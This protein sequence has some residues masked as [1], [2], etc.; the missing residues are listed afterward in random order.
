MRRF[1]LK[2]LPVYLGVQFAY[3]V[4]VIVIGS[5]AMAK[6]GLLSAPLEVE[7]DNW[8]QSPEGQ[9]AN[10]LLDYIGKGDK[11]AAQREYERGQE[12]FGWKPAEPSPRS[13]PG[14]SRLGPPKTLPPEAR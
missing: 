5:L 6:P 14:P 11:A 8:D 9:A 3:L 4:F 2:R 13:K 12:A 10:R 1:L 7:E